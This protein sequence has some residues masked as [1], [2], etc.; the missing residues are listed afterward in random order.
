V[1]TISETLAAAKAA[2]N[3]GQLARAEELFRQ[4][5]LL[6]ATNF[7]A[8]Y[9][10]G[11]VCHQLARPDD[12]IAS[13]TEAVRLKPELAAAHN[14]LG[15]VLAEQARIDRAIASFQRAGQLDTRWPDPA[16]NLRRALAV[17]DVDQ[18]IKAAEQGR[19]DDAAA[20]FS[21]ALQ[22]APDH[23]DAHNNLGY[24]LQA[25]GRQRE[26]IPYFHKALELN[27]DYLPA[28]INLGSS[29][30]S[31]GQA[32]EAVCVLRHAA[33][34]QNDS[35]E[36]Y[37]NLGVAL[38][39]L[40]QV[41]EAMASY[42]RVLELSPEHPRARLNRALA[43]LLRGDFAVGWHEFEWRKPHKRDAAETPK[44]P[45][46][47]GEPLEG[48]TILLESEEGYGDTLQ[49]VRYAELLKGRGATV[50]VHCPA[51]TSELLASCRGVDRVLIAGEPMP[52][53][54]YWAPMM[55]LGGIVGTSLDNI[56]ANVPYLRS[57]AEAVERWRA[58]LSSHEGF[59]VG[60]AWQGNPTH[61]S[62]FYR[63]IPLSQFAPIA[64]VPGI[65]LYSLQVGPGRE[66]LADWIDRWPITDL[67]DRLG[68]FHNTAA[69]VSN[70]D[71]VITCDSAPA[72]LAGALGVPVW[73]ALAITPDWRWLL[74]RSDSPWYP[75]ARLFRQQQPG[76]W[77]NV[78]RAIGQEL[79]KAVTAAERKHGSG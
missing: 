7:E 4:I 15:A 37:N 70:L 23:V 14:H 72:H 71:L 68:D 27:A 52:H 33:R 29:L 36:V 8:R 55:S 45:R 50:F 74:G 20:C 60:I 46:W 47:T 10:H 11:V 49:F 19:L 21:R 57:D 56:P 69:A 13:F 64:A 75:T 5:A 1:A 63:S 42:Q 28:Y 77:E 61:K 18:G 76:D 35:A 22:S 38:Y 78:F 17:K 24:V 40:G 59:K 2:Q 32:A 31:I 54:D 3:A 25:Q 12:A 9:L 39:S 65:H 16:N 53:V 41:D 6:D 34:L 58:E 48:R 62:D 79:M 73:L 30:E 26:A 43:L 51:A 66:Q 67:A 44:Q